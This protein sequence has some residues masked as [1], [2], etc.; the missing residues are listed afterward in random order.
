VIPGQ[1]LLRPDIMNGQSCRY[2]SSSS[3]LAAHCRQM[4][5]EVVMVRAFLEKCRVV[6]VSAVQAGFD[7]VQP[8]R[9]GYVLQQQ[10]PTGKCSLFFPPPAPNNYIQRRSKE[11]YHSYGVRSTEPIDLNRSTT[12]SVDA[13]SCFFSFQ[14]SGP[15]TDGS[16]PICTPIRSVREHAGSRKIARSRAR[17]QPAL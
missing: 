16:P 15:T 9:V 17:T 7:L 5:V 3:S 10:Q 6:H 11:V 2:S 1:M 12:E 4:V 14:E 8:A 13:S